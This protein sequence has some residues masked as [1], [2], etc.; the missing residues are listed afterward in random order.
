VDSNGNFKVIYVNAI[1]EELIQ[2]SKSFGNF[3]NSNLPTY[4]GKP[5]YS[6]YIHFNTIEEFRNN[7]FRALAREDIL[8]SN[9]EQLT[10]LDSIVYK[11]I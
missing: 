7:S 4:N 9:R 2:E 1:D 6:K 5:T 3:E 8:Q 10:E 11:K